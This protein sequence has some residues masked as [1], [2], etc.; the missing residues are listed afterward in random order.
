MGFGRFI[1]ANDSDEPRLPTRSGGRRWLGRLVR[2]FFVS[3]QPANRMKYERTMLPE[4]AKWESLNLNLLRASFTVDVEIAVSSFFFEVVAEHLICPTRQG[5]DR[6]EPTAAKRQQL[7]PTIRKKAL[8]LGL[9]LVLLLGVDLRNCERQSRSAYHDHC[10]NDKD[11]VT[12]LC[13][14][15][16]I[17]HAG[18]A[19]TEMWMQ[20]NQPKTDGCPRWMCR[21]VR[22]RFS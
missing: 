22:L 21:L 20:V 4:H 13:R 18:R 3:G 10:E 19:K 17:S 12:H 2:P 1:L 8:R 6:T 15:I 14:T 7:E 9:Q 11:R 16:Q 5:E